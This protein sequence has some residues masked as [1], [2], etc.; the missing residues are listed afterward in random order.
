MMLRGE[1]TKLFTIKVYFTGIH[2]CANRKNGTIYILRESK[3]STHES[4]DAH[5][6]QTDG[7]DGY[8]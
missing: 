6:N 4:N 5:R 8:S 7:N 3:R 2:F 1:F